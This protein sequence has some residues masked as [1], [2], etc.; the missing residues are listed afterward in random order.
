[1]LGRERLR[2]IVLAHWDLLVSSPIAMEPRTMMKARRR[3]QTIASALTS[4]A[5]LLVAATAQAAPSSGPADALFDSARDAMAKG[6][7]ATA[8]PRFAESHRLDPAPGT[9][10]NLAQ[11]EEK[12]GKLTASMA[13]LDE[14][15]AALP[16]DDK[17]LSYARE[18]LASIKA[19]VPTVTLSMPDG[20]AGARVFF[21]DVELREA[22]FG[23]PLPVDPGAHVFVVRAPGRADTREEIK[24]SEGART[25]VTLRA[26]AAS[27]TAAVSPAKTDTSVSSTPPSSRRTLAFAALGVGAAGV[28]AG[29][30]TGILYMNARS[31][32]NER[33]DASGCDAQGLDAASTAKTLD[34][35]SPVAL[36]V[37][38]VGIGIGTYLLFTS[39]PQRTGMTIDPQVGTQSAGLT[40]R[41]GF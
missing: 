9:L 24:L 1:M 8:C 17:R 3:H 13:H 34:V 22:S 39:R 16:K 26:G 27:A 32:Y 10:L 7:Y 18:R 14:A 30:V 4:A 25:L 36:G 12:Q 29:A 2:T 31:T 28:V 35:V 19:R 20:A 40:L 11:C 15:V 41:G 5:L 38:A 37:G 21:D 6:D 33:C 23:V